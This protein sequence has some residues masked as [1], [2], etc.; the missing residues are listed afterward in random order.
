[1]KIF[2]SILIKLIKGYKFVISPLLGQS[3]RYLPTCSDY[4][5]EALKE[6]GL[7]KVPVVSVKRIL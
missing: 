4:L 2:T 5:I 3:C 7:F 6:L 1:M